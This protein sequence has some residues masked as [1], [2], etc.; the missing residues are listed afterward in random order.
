LEIKMKHSLGKPS[1]IFFLTCFASTLV[2]GAAAA[3]SIERSDAPGLLVQGFEA[4]LE[5]LDPATPAGRQEMRTLTRALQLSWQGLKPE[6]GQPTQLASD[7]K[8]ACELA[9]DASAQADLAKYWADQAAA[10]SDPDCDSTYTDD[11]QYYAGQA[12]FYA[13][14]AAELACEGPG[15][16]DEAEDQ[17]LDAKVR[18]T[19]ARNNAYHSWNQGV[20]GCSESL[21]T[22]LY[23][24][25]AVVL[26][27]NAAYYASFCS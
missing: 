15:S 19:N 25:N 24:S 11:A 20:D 12:A 23:S 27:H 14:A 4:R 16:A 3:G 5:A 13:D 9:I 26:L 7:C 18:A 6:A 17:L 8:T 2:A 22:Y 21:N 10:S 1:R